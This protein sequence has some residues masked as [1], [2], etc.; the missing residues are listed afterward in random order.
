MFIILGDDK[1]VD[2][3]RHKPLPNRHVLPV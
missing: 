3:L 1:A 2:N